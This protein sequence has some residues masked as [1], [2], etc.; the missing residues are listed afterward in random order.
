MRTAIR[1]GALLTTLLLGA[2]ASAPTQYYTLTPVGADHPAPRGSAGY[3]IE[4]ADVPLP[5]TIDRS[6]IVLNKG[7]GELYIPPND[8]WAAP[9]GS[10]IR[11]ALTGDLQSRLGRDSVLAPGSLA[12]H[13]NLRVLHLTIQQFMA[14]TDGRVVLTADWVLLRAGSSDVLRSGHEV[15]TTQ[16]TSGKVAAIVPAMSEALGKLA[17]RTAAR[18]G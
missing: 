4:V 8:A 1:I 6:G 7:N 16:A 13:R 2:C 10:L 3:V 18:I 11:E 9:L 17:D 14:D 5:A 15:I 12:P